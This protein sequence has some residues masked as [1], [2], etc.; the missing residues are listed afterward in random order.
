MN[1]QSWKRKEYESW[2]EA[3]RGL[4]PQ[5]RQQ[6][7]RVATYTQVLFVQACASSYGKNIAEWAERMK[8]EYVDLAYKCGLYHKL[9][10]ALLTPEHQLW[11][12]VASSE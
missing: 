6:S 10:K 2:D 9:G 4:L 3:F 12:K 7:V 1:E 5:I 11:R 8:D